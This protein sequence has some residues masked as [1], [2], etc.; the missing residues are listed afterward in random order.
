MSFYGK[1]YQEKGLSFRDI[2]FENTGKNKETFPTSTDK[3]VFEA[4]SAEDSGKIA[5]GN[6]WLSIGGAEDGYPNGL[7]LFHNKPGGTSSAYS[8]VS[9]TKA[10]T[11]DEVATLKKEGKQL[12]FGQGVV[13]ENFEYDKAGHIIKTSED[14]WLMPSAPSIDLADQLQADIEE[15]QIAVGLGNLSTEESLN[16]RVEK[17]E[18]NKAEADVV[19]KMDE[20]L[21][22]VKAAAEKLRADLGELGNLGVYNPANLVSVLGNVWNL[23]SNWNQDS[24]NFVNYLGKIADLKAG[25]VNSLVEGIN[26]VYELL[27]NLENSMNTANIAIEGLDARLKTIESMLGTSTTE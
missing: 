24:D 5:I 2:I 17:L 12:H 7:V 13:F 4:T 27:Q 15:L 6:R 10:L 20:T 26:Q 9:S 22:E 25:E 19:E 11:D 16:P 14:V 1:I 18:E 21:T 8:T 3:E 23:K